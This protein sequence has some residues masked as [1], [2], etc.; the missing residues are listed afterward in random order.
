MPCA[1]NMHFWKGHAI[2]FSI[3]GIHPL[4]VSAALSEL[5]GR[6][7]FD[8]GFVHADPHPGNVLVHLRRCAHTD[9]A[10]QQVQLRQR[11]RVLLGSL[12]GEDAL[13]AQGLDHTTPRIRGRLRL[14][15]LDH[16]LYCSLTQQFRYTY[17]RLWLAMQQGDIAAVT[18]CAN[19]FGVGK[20]AGLLAVILSLRSE[21]RCALIFCRSSRVRGRPAKSIVRLYANV[22]SSASTP[23]CSSLENL[24]SKDHTTLEIIRP[25]KVIS[26]AWLAPL[27]SLSGKLSCGTY[28]Q[29]GGTAAEVVPRVLRPHHQC[30]AR[31]SSRARSPHQDE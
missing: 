21:D 22:S 26:S 4:A 19:E 25:A 6:L 1:R 16:G 5:Y 23:D 28:D 14:T 12:N 2:S 20:L 15:L 29:R 31:S 17:A 10:A 11:T 9:R 27:D 30:A 7:I 8:V 3:A 24:L 18:A 13:Q